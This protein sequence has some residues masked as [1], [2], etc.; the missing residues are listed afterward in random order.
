MT[1]HPHSLPKLILSSRMVLG[2]AAASQEAKL[3]A[4][5]RFGT[6]ESIRDYLAEAQRAGFGAILTLGDGRVVAALKLLRRQ[7]ANGNGRGGGAK[8]GEFQV[9]PIIPNVLG[10]VREAT[11]YGLA[12]AGIRRLLRVG[13]LGF[14]RASMVGALNAPKVLRKD[15]PTLLS[16]LYELEMGEFRQFAPPVV[17][18]HHQMTD[19]ALS[20]GNRAF[21]EKYAVLMRDRFHT[22][23]GLVTSNFALLAA[24]LTEW[25]VPIWHIAAPFNRSNFL[26][27]GGQDAYCRALEGGRFHLIADRISPEFPTPTADIEWALGQPRVSSVVVDLMD[28]TDAAQRA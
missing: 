26:M 24:R 20:F 22:E 21:F 6:P 27:P 3:D 7:A 1:K 2:E 5:A 18:L 9:L 17:F 4:L 10:Y 23:P 14:L 16:I 11:E 15:F 28:R 25:N 8:R 13:P 12:G 19:L